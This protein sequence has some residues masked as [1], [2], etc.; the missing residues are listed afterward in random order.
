MKPIC[1]RAFVGYPM[2]AG[3]LA[4]SAAIGCSRS[5]PSHAGTDTGV[6]LPPGIDAATD[7]Y[8]P[9]DAENEN[10]GAQTTEGGAGAGGA[11]AGTGGSPMGIAGASG[12][13]GTTS[14]GTGGTFSPGCHYDCFGRTTCADGVVT[15]W[16][17]VPV[18]C[19]QW[20]GSCPH[21]IV[22]MCQKGCGASNSRIGA[23]MTCPLV[24]CKENAPKVL[25]D[26]CETNDDCRPSPALTGG[27]TPENVY[28]RCDITAGTCVSATAPVLADWLAPCTPHVLASFM[29]VT[30]GLQAVVDS[31]CSS[32]LCLAAGE[33]TCVRQGCTMACRS[34]D[35]C[36][37][38]SLCMGAACDPF[39]STKA[40]FC[41]VS[42]QALSCLPANGQ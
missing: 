11:V 35:E 16:A 29:G 14:G 7:S 15:S 39:A 30:T 25:G 1:V 27:A 26:P 36:P 6:D 41:A 28:L 22:G 19:S 33:T 31:R 9:P 37:M 4:A 38:S 13:G 40:G 10:D 32:G 34:D 12:S 18:P 8:D 3:L 21:S 20:T 24:V 42:T 5:L 2:L 23:S 17:N